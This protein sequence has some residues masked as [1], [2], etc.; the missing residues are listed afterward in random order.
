MPVCKYYLQGIC[1]RNKCPYL[2]K[3]LSNNA[4]ICMDF[5]RGY[6]DLADKVCS[7]MN[8]LQFIKITKHINSY[9]FITNILI[10]FFPLKV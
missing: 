5:L 8:L 9:I 1:V 2:H 3:K 6:C 4:E 7:K 10:Y